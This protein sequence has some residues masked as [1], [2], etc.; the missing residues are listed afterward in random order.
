MPLTLTVVAMLCVAGTASAQTARAAGSVRDVDGKPIKG[1]TIRATN[2]E[3]YPPQVVSTSDDRG[4]W[5]MIG[6]RIGTYGFV[7]EAPG[8]LPVQA[9]ATVRTAAAAPM[10]FTMARDPGPIP[11][12]LPSNIQAQLSAASMLRDQGRLDQAISAYQEIR[13]KNPKLT[14]VNMVIG[15]VYRQRA[16]QEADPAARRTWLDRAIESYSEVLKSD[17]D[18]ERARR[19]LESTRTE[20]AGISR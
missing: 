15:S 19:E 17:T 6:M 1:A 20:V 3:A 5:A 9:S 8:F 12:A 10:V 7:V 2:P 13:V 16:S 18:N 4:R 14:S 11:G